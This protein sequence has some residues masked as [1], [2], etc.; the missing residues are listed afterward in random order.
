MRRLGYALIF[1]AL[2]SHAAAMTLTDYITTLERIQSLVTARQY[3]GA[4]AAAQP[5]RGQSVDSPNGEF[6]A[7]ETIITALSADRIDPRFPTRLA[8]TI[9]E[10]RAAGG[11]AAVHDTDRTLIDKLDT[12]QRVPPPGADGDVSLGDSDRLLK[13]GTAIQEVFEKIGKYLE[14]FFEWLRRDRKDT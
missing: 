2:A 9:S 7:D 13:V 10:L 8:A 6:H 12:E 14:E 3:A 5:L 1:A 4:R 11:A